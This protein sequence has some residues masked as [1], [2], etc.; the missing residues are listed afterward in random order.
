ML[1]RITTT[2]ALLFSLILVTSCAPPAYPQ[3]AGHAHPL[4]PLTKP[5]ISAVVAVLKS[6]GKSHPGNKVC[7]GLSERAAKEPG[8]GGYR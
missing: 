7:P 5:E 1:I 4:D 6:T 2:L 8:D 3:R